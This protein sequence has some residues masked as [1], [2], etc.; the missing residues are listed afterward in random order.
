MMIMANDI[1]WRIDVWNSTNPDGIKG[2]AKQIEAAMELGST[3]VDYQGQKILH[4]DRLY[5]R[6]DLIELLD[7]DPD[8]LRIWNYYGTYKLHRMF[9]K[10]FDVVSNKTY[11][12]LFVRGF[13]V[14]FLMWHDLAKKFGVVIICRYFDEFGEYLGM[15]ICD[16]SD[17]DIIE[18]KVL[19]NEQLSVRQRINQI[20]L[21]LQVK[22]RKWKPYLE[23]VKTSYINLM[24]K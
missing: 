1:Y 10:R 19:T 6:Q 15:Q 12:R 23:R 5:Y 24:S 20:N 22:H 14:P 3:R 2:F 13:G 8:D 18:D 21:K 4:L 7:D 11:L 17:Y 9:V 16:E